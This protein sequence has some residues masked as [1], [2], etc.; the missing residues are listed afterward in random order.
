MASVLVID[1]EQVVR[2]YARTVLEG[3]G[4]RV[5]E[6][7]DGVEG[8][9]YYRAGRVD[10]VLCDLFM[11]VKNGLDTLRDFWQHFPEAKVIAMS[12]GA[13]WGCDD[14]LPAARRLGAVAVLPKPFTPSALIRMVQGI[15]GRSD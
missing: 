11:P 12:A 2:S 9:A 14:A 15:L 13:F 7:S 5:Y 10:L 6:A 8:L 1:D 4:H 3:V